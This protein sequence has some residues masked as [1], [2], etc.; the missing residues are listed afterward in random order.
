MTHSTQFEDIARRLCEEHEIP[1]ALFQAL[2][3]EERRVRHLKR[4][5]GITDRLRQMIVE[6]LERE[7]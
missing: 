2:L 4:R 6:T 3:D 7:E 1:Y 5:P